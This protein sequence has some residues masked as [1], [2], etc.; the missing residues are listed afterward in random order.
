MWNDR[1]FF[2]LPS[3]TLKMRVI[4]KMGLKDCQSHAIEST[5]LSL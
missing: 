1:V 2:L 3:S 4:L 5:L